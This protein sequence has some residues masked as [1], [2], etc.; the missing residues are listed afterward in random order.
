MTLPV[1]LRIAH[2]SRWCR[3]LT[4]GHERHVTACRASISTD[5]PLYLTTRLEPGAEVCSACDGDTQVRLGRGENMTPYAEQLGVR[6]DLSVEPTA[7]AAEELFG[8]VV[9]VARTVTPDLRGPRAVD[10]EAIE[11][12]G[13]EQRAVADGGVSP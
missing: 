3:L 11:E 10:V 13:D 6:A 12:W 8:P 7:R 5:W 4:I 9:A 1:Y 2:Y